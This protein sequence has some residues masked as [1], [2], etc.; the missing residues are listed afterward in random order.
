MSKLCGWLCS[1]V[2][3]CS[4]SQQNEKDGLCLVFEQ[5]NVPIFVS[6][7]A[8]NIYDIRL[9]VHIGDAAHHSS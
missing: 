6:M 3:Q 8:W 7:L 1:W 4:H 2:M 9:S 5:F